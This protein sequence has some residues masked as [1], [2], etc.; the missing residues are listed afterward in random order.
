MTG[1]AGELA[2]LDATAQAALVREGEVSAAELVESAIE[3]IE[4]LNPELGA[5]VVP[6]YDQARAAVADGTPSG[7]FGGVPYLLKDLIV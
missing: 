5:V 1:A 2:T 4:R 3:R 6:L 7:P